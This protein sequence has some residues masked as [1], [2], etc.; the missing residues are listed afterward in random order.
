[1]IEKLKTVYHV[2]L[3]EA[4]KH[5]RLD[6]DYI[7]DDNLIQAYIDAAHNI[8]ENEILKDISK[9]TNVLTRH[10]YAGSVIRVNEGNLI[11]ITSIEIQE[12]ET[13]LSN[14]NTFIYRDRF[15]IELDQEIDTEELT[16]TFQTGF[17]SGKCPP[18]IKTA[19]LLKIEDLYGTLRGSFVMG[20]LT[21]TGAFEALLAPYKAA[22]V[23]TEPEN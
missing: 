2:S 17:D 23:S 16:V 4:R 18:A 20:G 8:A 5:L 21:N 12:S 15:R 9:T 1:M 7:Q 22:H 14:F 13:P 10:D 3:E 6:D 19:I 11:S